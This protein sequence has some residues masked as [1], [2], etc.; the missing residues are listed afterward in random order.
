MKAKTIVSKIL[1]VKFIRI[2]LWTAGVFATL[3]F[4][5]DSFV[6][7]WY[8]NKGGT[9]TVPNV[10]GMTE[11]RAMQLLKE[12][13]LEPRKGD[14]RP[15][16]KIPI[17]SVITQN[18]LA[19]Q[20]VKLGR[21]VYLTISGGEQLVMVPLLRGR[22]IRDSK[23]S[24][25]RVGL[26]QGR[27]QYQTSQELPEG[28]IILQDI[29]QGVKVKRG[30]YIGITVSAGES[31]DSIYIPSFIGKTLTEARKMI[32]DKGLKVGT[33][34]YQVNNDLLPNTVIDQLPR[35]N[36]VVTVDKEIDLFVSQTAEKN[37]QIIREN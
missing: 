5:L 9:R 17:G 4:L 27:I 25:D 20:T 3:L 29:P 18:P 13:N 12:N 28:T 37:S 22:T 32:R 2:L 10:V 26:K 36:D 34:T 19:D 31:I 6:M 7:P 8:V 14:I 24:L 15:D 33:I 1:S 11:E 21:R 23:F 30:T 35:E 16:N